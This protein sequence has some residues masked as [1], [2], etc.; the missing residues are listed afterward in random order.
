[1]GGGVAVRRRH[2]PIMR[3][4][5]S[6]EAM[7]DYVKDGLYAVFPID[8]LAL[9]VGPSKVGDPDLKNAQLWRSRDIRRELNFEA[10]VVP[11]QS[12]EF[13]HLSAE[14]FVANLQV[15]QNL[16]VEHAENQRHHLVGEEVVI[17]ETTMRLAVEARPENDVG[18]IAGEER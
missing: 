11:A 13:N 14:H 18:L 5:R 1:M 9:V 2:G 10:E 17:I 8:L 12:Q 16:I 4:R 15:R 7:P 6:G 3:K